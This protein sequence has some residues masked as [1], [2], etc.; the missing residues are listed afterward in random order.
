MNQLKCQATRS[1]RSIMKSVLPGLLTATV[2][3]ATF[4][5]KSET[6]AEQ[7]P[8]RGAADPK[9]NTLTLET[10]TPVDCTVVG[11]LCSGTAAYCGGFKNN[12]DK[13]PESCLKK[14][15]DCLQLEDRASTPQIGSAAYCQ[16]FKVKAD[17]PS[18]CEW[19]ATNSQCKEISKQPFIPDSEN[20]SQF[21]N[22]A[23]CTGSC[24]WIAANQSCQKRGSQPVTP[25]PINNNC[26]QVSLLMCLFTQGCVPKLALPPICGPKL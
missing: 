9:C 14:S 7:G 3:C 2:V 15:D 19:S 22:Q 17:C 26:A 23:T 25:N 13:C 1:I 11:T 18:T 10:C 21:F 12:P 24:E 4:S 8:K 6:P 20:C 5:C 16:P